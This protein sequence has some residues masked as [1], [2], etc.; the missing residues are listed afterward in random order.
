MG[1]NILYRDKMTSENKLTTKTF[2]V[3][4]ARQASLLTAKF[5]C[6]LETTIKHTHTSSSGDHQ[7][8][9]AYGVL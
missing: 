6:L 5:S 3:L 7:S 4:R 9:S 8:N 2:S 1:N